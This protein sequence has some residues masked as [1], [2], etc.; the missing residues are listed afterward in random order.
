MDTR[1][2][3]KRFTIL[4]V[5]VALAAGFALAGCGSSDDDSTDTNGADQTQTTTG[6][7]ETDGSGGAPAGLVRGISNGMVITYN[8]GGFNLQLNDEASDDLRSQVQGNTVEV[9]CG[10]VTGSGEWVADSNAAT[11]LAEGDADSIDECTVYESGTPLAT[12]TMAPPGQ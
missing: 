11:F 1:S 6:G 8:K 12:A 9:K 4:F 7:S 3:P 10:E 2:L 5:A